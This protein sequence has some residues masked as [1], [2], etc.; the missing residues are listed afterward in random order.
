MLEVPLLEV[1][2]SR[3]NDHLETAAARHELHAAV[4]FEQASGGD[5]VRCNI[6]IASEAKQSR[7]DL[8]R[9]LRLLA[10]TAPRS[11]S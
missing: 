10:M 3:A 7:L 8:P 4:A 5:Y 2:A 9:R 1:A 6:V 11:I